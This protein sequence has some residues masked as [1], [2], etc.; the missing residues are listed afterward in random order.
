MSI[1]FYSNR[2][3]RLYLQAVALLLLVLLVL[4]GCQPK[5]RPAKAADLP[6]QGIVKRQL[7]E[8]GTYYVRRGD[9]LYAIAFSYGLDAME[10]AKLNGIDKPYT[11]YPGQ[12]LKLMSPSAASKS[13]T[14][15]SGVEINTVKTPS[16]ATTRTMEP[17][18]TT[19]SFEPDTTTA[20][21][22][23]KKT[24]GKAEPVEKAPAEPPKP[25]PS[26]T[27]KQADPG[28]WKWPT[29]GRVIRGFVAGDP[30]R[31][32]LDIAGKEGQP[33]IAAA[34]GE[35]V[36]SGNGLIGYGELIIV[37]HSEN[38]LSA[39]AHNRVRLVKEG[40]QVWSGQKIAEMGK[41]S[42][43]EPLLHFE[44]RQQGKPVNPMNFLPDK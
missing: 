20:A 42:S 24:A 9:T 36:Y 43:D 12:K 25:A 38:M 22:A 37:K 29:E 32:G 35:V 34:A 21:P 13:T 26:P 11:I 7:N 27:V 19:R 44:I 1:G 23:T 30:A 39:Y 5:Y 4:P 3:G 31:N 17:R 14:G 2:S 6:E 18:A 40:D 8:D 33:I 10:I 16:A 41:N 28:A 15:S